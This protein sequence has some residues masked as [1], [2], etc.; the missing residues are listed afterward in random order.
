MKCTICG[1]DLE[2]TSTDLPFKVSDSGIV[3]VK[4]L[5]VLQC[6]RCPHYLIADRALARVDEIL[7]RLG[8]GTEL[9]VVRYAA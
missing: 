6:S 8:S 9:E 4:S 1:A 3:I 2:E 7:E 5:P